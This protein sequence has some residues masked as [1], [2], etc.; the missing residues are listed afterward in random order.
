MCLISQH[1]MVTT[2]YILKN[3]LFPF[4]IKKLLVRLIIEEHNEEIKFLS[5]VALG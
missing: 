2:Q 4:D 5:S 3:L 1:E